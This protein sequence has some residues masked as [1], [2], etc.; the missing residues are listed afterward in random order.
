VTNI[1]RGYFSLNRLWLAACCLLVAWVEPGAEE[2]T[3]SLIHTSGL[4]GNLEHAIKIQPL[5]K[6]IQQ[7]EGKA[8]LLNAGSALSPGESAYKGQGNSLTVSLFNKV[9]LGVWVPGGDDFA[10]SPDELS[11][12]LRDASFPILG[13]NLHRSDETGRILSQIQPFTIVPMGRLKIGI[14]GLSAGGNKVQVG[15]PVQAAKYYVPILRRV[16]DAV[17]LVTHLG[18]KADSTLA[19]EVEDIDVIIGAQ[20]TSGSITINGVLLGYATGDDEGVGRIDLKFC[21]GRVL[22]KAFE[23]L[24]LVGKQGP[25]LSQALSGWTADV[26][27][28]PMPAAAI[29]GT[30]GGGFGSSLGKSSAMGHLIADLM[31]IFVGSDLAFVAASNVDPE[32]PEGAIT[33]LD[34]FR[35]YGWSNQVVIVSVKGSQLRKFLEGG[36]ET[37]GGFFYPSGLN[38]VYDLSAEKGKSVASIT[39]GDQPLD[40]N[41]SYR[42][43]VEDRIATTEGAGKGLADFLNAGGRAPTGVLIRD[44]IARHIQT[45]TQIK[46][47]VDDRVQEK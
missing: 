5:F 39:V 22:A 9:G 42:A 29:I 15:D 14:L 17:V 3:V 8:L 12:F 10:R 38:V 27:G 7:E 1:A 25:S 36:L 4:Q 16:A 34:L 18:F 2:V 40:D 45:L 28:Q 11:T 46:G 23:L 19:E 13:A 26:D 33:V 30:S 41:K 37:T 43:A 35:V 47:N 21:D 32:L 24:S 6:Q 44:L 31:R 20:S